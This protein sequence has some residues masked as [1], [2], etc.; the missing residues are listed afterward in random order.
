MYGVWLRGVWCVVRCVSSMV[1]RA[2]CIVHGVWCAVRGVWC[3]VTFNG[4]V[5]SSSSYDHPRGEF[6]GDYAY[7]GVST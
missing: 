5:G 1:Y 3:G 7:P 4:G 6:L 2:L